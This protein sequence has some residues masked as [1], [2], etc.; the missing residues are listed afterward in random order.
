MSKRVQLDFRV[1][2][3]VDV[4]DKRPSHLKN[5]KTLIDPAEYA[6]RFISLSPCLMGNHDLDFVDGQI[7]KGLTIVDTETEW[8]EAYQI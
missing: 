2:V 5:E 8:V 3:V 1:T 7:V 4:A 6:R